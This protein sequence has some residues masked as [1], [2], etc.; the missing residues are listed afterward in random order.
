MEISHKELNT[1]TNEKKICEDE[2]KCEESK[3][4]TRKYEI[5]H[6]KFKDLKMR[7]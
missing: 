5:K 7:L 1:N 3:W 4:K 6:C 2:R